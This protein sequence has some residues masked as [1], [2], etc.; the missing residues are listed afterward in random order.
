MNL[1]Q[2]HSVILTGSRTLVFIRTK[3][4]YCILKLQYIALGMLT[5]VVCYKDFYKRERKVIFQNCRKHTFCVFSEEYVMIGFKNFPRLY[6][7]PITFSYESSYCMSL[8]SEKKEIWSLRGLFTR[9]VDAMRLRGVSNLVSLSGMLTA[10]DGR[11][12]LSTAISN[13]INFSSK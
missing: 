2:P 7:F 5:S 10:S 9:P 1:L 12:G 6:F 11:P 8:L 3:R 13:F 4:W